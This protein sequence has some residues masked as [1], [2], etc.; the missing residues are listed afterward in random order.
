VSSSD[1]RVDQALVALVGDHDVDAVAG[2]PVGVEALRHDRR[3]PQQSQRVGP[4]G[5]GGVGGDVDDVDERDRHR[6]LDPVRN[7][8][9]RVRRQQQELRAG[10]LEAA[11]TVD[12]VVSGPVPGP[13]ADAVLD[14]R[15]V[16]AVDH[17]IG[18]GVP[19]AGRVDALVEAPVVLPGRDPAYPAED[20]DRLHHATLHRRPAG[21]PAI[22]ARSCPARSPQRALRSAAAARPVSGP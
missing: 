5:A 6:G 7:P 14:D 16:H 22:A 15:E 13:G 3:G 21:P 17:D 20:P 19:P 2:E 8:V 10:P 18:G 1:H 4:V 9:H 11:G 12:Q